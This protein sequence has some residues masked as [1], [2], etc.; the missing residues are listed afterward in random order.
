VTLGQ[1]F[2]WTDKGTIVDIIDA[3]LEPRGTMLLIHHDP[4]SPAPQVD[5]PRHPL[6]PR[7]LIATTRSSAT[8]RM[9]SRRR[10]PTASGMRC[11][12]RQHTATGL[13][14]DWPGDTEVLIAR[15]RA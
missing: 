7:A 9:G 2:H 4:S 15:K 6:I 3:S 8:S 1:S 10:T 11:S 12:S 14:W 13:F 5:E